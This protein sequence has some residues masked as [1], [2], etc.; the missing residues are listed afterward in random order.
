VR[1][2]LRIIEA[3]AQLTRASVE[4]KLRS[5]PQAMALLKSRGEDGEADAQRLREATAVG[6][7]VERVARHLPWHPTCLRQALA[8]QRML[9]GR[10]IPSRLHLGVSIAHEAHAWVTV[11]GHPVVG[12]VELE[13]YVALER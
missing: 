1:A 2:R 6:R 13:R 12:D 8:A 7:D 3:V 11:A 5:P 4:L 9:T 10:G